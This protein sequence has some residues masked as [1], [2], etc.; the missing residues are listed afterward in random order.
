MQ[1]LVSALLLGYLALV[2]TNSNETG[3]KPNTTVTADS[4]KASLSDVFPSENV[5]QTP[6][7]IISSQFMPST[8]ES[9]IRPPTISDNAKSTSN[10]VNEKVLTEGVKVYAY[11]VPLNQNGETAEEVGTEI[12]QSPSQENKPAP[13]SS[14]QNVDLGDNTQEDFFQYS[15]GVNET[16]TKKPTKTL[17]DKW[18]KKNKDIKQSSAAQQETSA[19]SY[20]NHTSQIQGA[21]SGYLLTHAHDEQNENHV[22]LP[23]FEHDQQSHYILNPNQHQQTGINHQQEV[24]YSLP[25]VQPQHHIIYDGQDDHHGTGEPQVFLQH[26]HIHAVHEGHVHAH[27]KLPKP[28]KPSIV[29][30]DPYDFYNHHDKIRTQDKD[31]HHEQKHHHKIQDHGYN[32]EHH[33]LNSYSGAQYV[34]GF[35]PY[36]YDMKKVPECASKNKHFYNITFCL[37]DHLYP[38]ETILWALRQYGDFA[39][40]IISDVTY[41]SADNLVTGLTRAEEEGYT[42]KHY[43]GQSH[44]QHTNLEQYKPP[45]HGYTYKTDYFKKGGYICPSDIYY[46]RPKRAMNTYGQ[47][48]VIVNVDHVPKLHYGHGHGIHKKR[49]AYFPT[50][51]DYEIPQKSYTQTLRMEQCI[52][53]NAPCSYIDPH[54]HSKCIQKHNFIRL[55]AWTEHEGLHVDTFKMPIA[56]SCHIPQPIHFFQQSGRHDETLGSVVP[57]VNNYLK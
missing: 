42:Y 32:H 39:H 21:G 18:V 54:F 27:H 28:L 43:F 19:S 57:P 55:V 2:A 31:H 38:L 29:H 46:G 5:P 4:L 14:Y 25:E 10:I 53:P 52:Y 23:H 17:K 7:E 22:L 41:Q 49:S 3:S 16:P 24:Q 26:P 47:W 37:E 15:S 12:Q 20:G 1:G 35:Q 56:C 34:E 33:N 13:S 6:A 40:K 8:S 36:D 11:Q 44:A 51:K 30:R 48:K 45:Y 9:Q 50:H